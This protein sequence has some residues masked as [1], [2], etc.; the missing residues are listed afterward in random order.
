MVGTGEPWSRQCRACW[1]SAGDV[2]AADSQGVVPMPG[3]APGSL[4]SAVL[5][6]AALEASVGLIGFSVGLIH[7]SSGAG[8]KQP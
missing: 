8:T 2:G 1:V 7:V 3:W 4:G 5:L 6:I